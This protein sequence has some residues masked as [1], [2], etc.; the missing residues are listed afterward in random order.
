MKR[1]QPNSRLLRDLISFFSSHLCLALKLSQTSLM[2][3][4]LLGHPLLF[5]KP[6]SPWPCCEAKLKS[7]WVLRV[8]CIE[9]NKLAERVGLRFFYIVFWAGFQWSAMQTIYSRRCSPGGMIPLASMKN[10]IGGEPVFFIVPS[11]TSLYQTNK[12]LML[13]PPAPFLH[14]MKSFNYQWR[15]QNH[16]QLIFKPVFLWQIG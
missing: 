15:T 3:K 7:Y 14:L 12:V 10:K 5:L 6:F 9:F 4:T 8:V 11:L 13:R 1:I 16:I 2:T